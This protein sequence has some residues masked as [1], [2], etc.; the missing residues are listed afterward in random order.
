MTGTVC[1]KP[2]LNSP[3]KNRP[4]RAVVQKPPPTSPQGTSFRADFPEK[5]P[6]NA[7]PVEKTV[8]N[9][10]NLPVQLLLPPVQ[11]RPLP[12]QFPTCPRA[13]SLPPLLLFFPFSFTSIPTFFVTIN[14]LFPNLL[15]FSK[16]T[17]FSRFP[18]IDILRY[19]TAPD[20]FAGLRGGMLQYS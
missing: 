3:P 11:F 12:V 13:N 20:R 14:F 16:N 4:F 9:P 6:Q 5:Q 18:L 8:H 2:R 10:P 17:F 15:T 1:T 19:I 7:L